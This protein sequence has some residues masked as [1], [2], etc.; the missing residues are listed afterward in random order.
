MTDGHV[1][2]LYGITKDI[3]DKINSQELHE[4]KVKIRRRYYPVANAILV[5]QVEPVTR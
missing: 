1:H 3:A 4:K 5:S 2:P